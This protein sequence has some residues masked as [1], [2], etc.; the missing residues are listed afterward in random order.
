VRV[1]AKQYFGVEGGIGYLALGERPPGP[2]SG[3]LPLVQFHAEFARADLAKAVALG[4]RPNPSR[5][6]AR[7]QHGLQG[8]TV[9]AEDF[10]L[11]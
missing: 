11:E 4:G 2:I 8:E 3:L 9:S 7:I 6:V 1:Q 5:H 10:A